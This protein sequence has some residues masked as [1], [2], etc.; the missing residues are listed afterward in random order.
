MAGITSLPSLSTMALPGMKGW[1]EVP[2]MV[3]PWAMMP[4]KSLGSMNL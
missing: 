4:E 3:P 2:R 1:R